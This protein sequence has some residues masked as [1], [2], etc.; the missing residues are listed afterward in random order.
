M[1][2]IIVID[3]RVTNRQVLSALAETI[4]TGA[5]TEAFAEPALALEKV[6]SKT[7]DLVVTDFNMPDM[8]GAEF[9]RRFR[10]MPENEDVPVIVVSAYEDRRYRYEALEAGA[11][12]FLRSPIDHFE[13]KA[14]ARNLL[15]FRKQQQLLRRRAIFL[16]DELTNEARRHQQAVRD[17]RRRLA[18]VIDNVSAMIYAV[19]EDRNATFVNKSALDF[20]GDRL[21][22]HIAD[23]AGDIEKFRTQYNSKNGSPQ[24]LLE[25]TLADGGGAKRTFLTVKTLLVDPETKR[26]CMLSV[27]TDITVRKQMEERLRDAMEQAQSASHA[28]SQFLMN[29]SHELRTP[30]NVIIGFSDLLANETLG[31]IEEKKYVQHA[32]EIRKSGRHLLHIINEVLELSRIDEGAV[33]LREEDADL[34]EIAKETFKSVQSE[35]EDCDIEFSFS[36]EFESVKLYCDAEKIQRVFANVMSNAVKFTNQKGSVAVRVVNGSDGVVVVEIEDD[37]IGMDEAEIKTALSRFS[38]VYEDARTKKYAGAGLGLPVAKGLMERHG[39]E[40]AVRGRKDEGLCVMLFFP[41][42]RVL[43]ANPAVTSQSL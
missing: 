43:E 31:P 16:E 25:E 42:A 24:D 19:D 10:S 29:M 23:N 12:D 34:N 7:P 21:A 1:T 28:K 36:T 2:H 4:E 38:Q 3:D 9:I 41:A 20:F 32:E 5:T 39:G 26:D 13:F 14:R 18:A 15:M 6:K 27:A 37:G 35:H 30:L 22:E 11:T 17:S 8:D 33:E 40:L